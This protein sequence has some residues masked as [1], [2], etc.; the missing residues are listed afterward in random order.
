[1]KLLSLHNIIIF[2][3]KLGNTKSI[4][5]AEVI[6]MAIK[7]SDIDYRIDNIKNL[8]GN[9]DELVVRN[10]TAG[11]NFYIELA[12]IYI[13]GLAN[14]DI[15]DRDILSPLM[16]HMKDNLMGIKNREDYIYKKYIAVSNTTVETDL[17]KV[18]D[19]IKRGKTILLVQGSTNYIV[20]DTA[21]GVYRTISEPVNDP[22]LRGPREGFV[23]NL[24]TNI[25]ILRRKIK[26]KNL[27]TEKFT[28]GRRSQTDLVIMY[29]DDVVDKDF[30]QKIRDRINIIDIDSIPANSIIE[31]CI[32]EHPYSILPQTNGSERPDVI[33]AALMEGKI[34]FLLSGTPY[35]LTYPSIF[36]EF[37]QTMED[38]YGR[39]IQS[40]FT[41]SLRF[42]AV[43]LVIFLPSIYITFIKFN[44]ELIPIEYIKSLI[45][46]R[47]GI[48]LTPFMSM[49]AIQL[50]IELLREGGLRMPSKIGQTLSVVGG[51]II[52]DAALK[53][54]FISSSILLIAGIATVASFAISNYQMSIAIRFLSYPMLVLSN[55]LGA[56]GIVIGCFFMLAYLCSLENFGVPYF[57]FHKS[58]MKDIFI[59]APIW[60]MNK[61]PDAIPHNDS[62]R[63]SDFRGNKNE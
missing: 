11:K 9:I 33:Q 34:A 51:I 59:R 41:R 7:Q 54:K 52:G 14:K 31:Q 57:S 60:K 50:T 49:I 48:A 40:Y 6:L 45:Q 53:A 46:D 28:L 25:S 1:M 23:E 18:I 61:R 38:Y 43:F 12:V 22:S 36:I 32:E 39:S 8:V 16:L 30:L 19:N 20:I 24:E 63:Q 58:D 47:N 27:T 35:V 21:G 3:I 17:N 44:A 55:W 62:V 26:D 4:T 13:N 2:S 42:I 29:L 15:I 56:L 37:F 10:F 5:N